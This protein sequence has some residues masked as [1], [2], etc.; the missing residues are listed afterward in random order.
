MIAGWMCSVIKIT[1]AAGRGAG[2][3]HTGRPRAEAALAANPGGPG[4]ATNGWPDS[5][6]MGR[7][8]A[9]QPIMPSQTLCACQP[10]P[11]SARAA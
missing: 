11:A 3:G 6:V 9:C 2:E 7:P 8:A 4:Q 10:A 1:S 5:L